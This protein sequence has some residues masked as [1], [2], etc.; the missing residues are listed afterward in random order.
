MINEPFTAPK[1]EVKEFPPIPKDLYQAELLDVNL[2]EGPTYDTRNK[3]DHE[4]VMEKTL[5]F[6]FTLLDGKDGETYLRGRNVWANLVPTYLNI[7]T[8][9]GKN[10]LYKIVEAMIGR[11]L[12]PEEEARG[13]TDKDLNGLVSM[14]I[15]LAIEP[16]KKGD[17]V[18]NNIT[19]F[20]KINNR[21]LALTPKEREDATVRKEGEMPAEGESDHP[22][23][24]VPMPKEEQ[25]TLDVINLPF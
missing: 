10:K 16:N 3:P 5:S 6:Q 18:Y 7:S 2:K 15:R 4:K 1:R 13:I 14:Q 23:Y 11:E 21:M 22:Q 19:D 12:T 20:Y 8:K 24:Q 9:N 17:K 25:E